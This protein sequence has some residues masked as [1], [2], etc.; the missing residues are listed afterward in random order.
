MQTRKPLIS[1]LCGYVAI[2]RDVITPSFS[3][4]MKQPASLEV[5]KA[6]FLDTQQC[7]HFFVSTR[8]FREDDFLQH[9]DSELVEHELARRQKLKADRDRRR[10]EQK[11]GENHG[12]LQVSQN[13]KW[14]SMHMSLATER[15]LTTVAQ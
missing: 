3:A 7:R 1:L 9:E 5:L 15:L 11:Q 13:D 2:F 14:K 12:S 4:I 6:V 8:P 10:E